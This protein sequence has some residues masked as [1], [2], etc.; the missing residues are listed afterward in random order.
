MVTNRKVYIEVLSFAKKGFKMVNQNLE[1]RREF[2]GNIW[3]G[4]K[5]A[6]GIYAVSKGMDSL[7]SPIAFAADPKI[8]TKIYKEDT[9]WLNIDTL[10]YSGMLTEREMMLLKIKQEKEQIYDT[11]E[12][13]EGFL[14]RFDN[15]Q[16]FHY[17]VGEKSTMG[18]DRFIEPSKEDSENYQEFL[19]KMK[20]STTKIKK[21]DKDEP[22]KNI[23]IL[24]VVYD[25][26][27]EKVNGLKSNA[28]QRMWGLS[29]DIPYQPAVMLSGR[30]KGCC[31][32]KGYALMSIYNE[33]G[34]KSKL[35]TGFGI[36]P[37]NTKFGHAWTR[38]YLNNDF[39]D[40]DP[41]LDYVFTLRKRV[42]DK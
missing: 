9:R 42:E 25:S 14:G 33:I 22:E 29:T 23:E 3:K 30:V 21:K 1:T 39:F 12:K 11:P 38:V 41:L 17:M 5:V 10:E 2:L 40:L 34:I 26:F 20:K 4:L 36:N 13:L 18:F 35:G 7:L 19:D 31:A 15:N 6:G 32:D 16:R 8:D 37:D 24:K 27:Q 28:N